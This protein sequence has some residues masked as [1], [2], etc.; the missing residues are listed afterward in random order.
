ME[1]QEAVMAFCQS[2]KIKS[3]LIWVSQTFQLMEELPEPQKRGAAEIIKSLII[4]IAHETK[5][6]ERY[7][8]DVTWAD[9][10]K[11]IEQAIVMIDSGVAFEAVPLLTKSLSKITNIGHRSMSFLKEQKLI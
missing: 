6:A 9:A 7:A 10:E 4:M 8:D 3:G 1:I 2:E 11:Y 5:L